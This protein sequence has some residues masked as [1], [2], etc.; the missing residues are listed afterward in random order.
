VAYGLICATE[1]TT[2]NTSDGKEGPGEITK[3]IAEFFG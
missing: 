2:L 1:A 3:K